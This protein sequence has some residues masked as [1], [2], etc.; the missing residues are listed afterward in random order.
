MKVVAVGAGAKAKKK[1]REVGEGSLA[2]EEE[3]GRGVEVQTQRMIAT[4]IAAGA[5]KAIAGAEQRRRLKLRQKE[6]RCQTLVNHLL[7]RTR[8]IIVG[9]RTA[10]KTMTTTAQ[11]KS[12]QS[13]QKPREPNGVPQ[14][15]NHK[16]KIALPQKM[17]L[18]QKHHSNKSHHH[19]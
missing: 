9:G 15:N 19:L 5:L 13:K 17:T 11:A 3:E 14:R 2:R 12:K 6:I 8:Q 18:H 16:A 10:V 7:R 4:M 1:L